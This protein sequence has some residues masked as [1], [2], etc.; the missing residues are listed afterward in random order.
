MHRGPGRRPRQGPHG[1][2]AA[3]HPRGRSWQTAAPTTHASG[4]CPWTGRAARSARPDRNGH[5]TGA[6]GSRRNACRG[7]GP[8]CAAPGRHRAGRWGPRRA[9]HRSTRWRH[10]GSRIRAGRRSGRAGV[11][12]CRPHGRGPARPHTA[13]HRRPGAHSGSGGPHTAGRTSAPARTGATARATPAAAAMRRAL[14][15]RADA[16]RAAR[17]P[18]TDRWNTRRCPGCGR[19]PPVPAWLQLPAAGAARRFA[20]Q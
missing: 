20:A 6:A 8:G 14:R 13:C 3:R 1:G 2:A 15:R 12:R 18:A 17:R 9:P 10:D 11:H 19:S 5:P 7:D 4:R 16:H